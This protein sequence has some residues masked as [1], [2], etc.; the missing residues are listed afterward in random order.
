MRKI[1]GSVKKRAKILLLKI[2]QFYFHIAG[3]KVEC[4]ICNFKANKFNSGSWH[5]YCTCPLCSSMVRQ[6]LLIASLTYLDEL[7]FN[8]II[9][10]KKVLHFAP[11][12]SLRKLIQSKA[13]EYKTA[14]F[15][16]EGYAYD[17]I[18]YNIDISDMKALRSESFDCIIACDVLEHV[19]DHIGGMTE[20]Y[21]VLNRDGYC[22]LTV[23]QK[24]NLK[25]T[26]E[27]LSI[28]DK[29]ERERLFGQS[30]HLRIYG[31][32]FTT[33]LQYV[34]FKVTA[35]DESFFDRDIVTRHVLFPPVLSKHP[36]ATNYRKIFFGRKL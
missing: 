35:V 4:N 7:S 6:R 21:R 5:L 16:A 15:L 27:D 33:M 30:D 3:S 19:T 9:N 25:K 14:D 2:Q 28:T 17:N 26:F 13:K 34:G 12:K 31:D 32:D 23:P 20:V 22:I 29:K 11:E 8:R 36:L 10:D 24:D 1:L 18:D